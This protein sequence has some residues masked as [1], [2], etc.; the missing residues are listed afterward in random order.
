MHDRG[1]K[2]V[3]FLSNHWD[4]E[5]GKLAL[6][7]RQVL[8]DEVADAVSMYG[9]DGVNID[10]E[11]MTEV[12]R[13]NYTDFVK[14]LSTLLPA[15]KTLA[16]AVAANPYGFEEG[17]Q[18]SYDYK[19]LGQY[20]DYLMIMAYDEHYPG[21]LAGPVAS[22]PFVENSIRYALKTAPS[23]KIVLGI[24]FYGRLWKTGSGTEGYG[25]SITTIEKMINE[26]NGR[27]VYD[28]ESQSSKAVFT[29]RPGEE[30][31]VL[32]GNLLP[33]GTYE[34]WYENDESLKYKL[35]LVQ[36]YN[37]KG[38][39]SWSLGQENKNIWNFYSLWL[40]GHYF[41][42]TS[43]NWALGDIL[44]MVDKGWM[45]GV[46]NTLFMPGKALTRAEAAAEFVRALGLVKQ[47]YDAGFSDIEGHWAKDD[48]ITAKQ[49]GIVTGQGNGLFS[50]E[51]PV[52]REE[53][54][55]MLDRILQQSETPVEE[56]NPYWDVSREENP[57]AYGSILDMTYQGGF[58]GRPDGAF[59]AAESVTRAE[60]AALMNRISSYIGNDFAAIP[61]SNP[62]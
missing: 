44:A 39:G 58:K 46:S 57:W 21:G 6:A 34:V 56:Y 12:D 28:S 2:V 45:K 47:G 14:R 31:F 20:S 32:E 37:L 1:I 26:Y 29:I 38:T 18:A 60:M 9:L 25:I 10:I 23:G 8:A 40:N 50:P 42:D 55:V 41:V 13:N 52:T 7:N 35:R 36:K 27:V 53:M 15:T 30:K 54:A 22:G 33:A 5:L 61:G 43:G 62:S 4:H 51:A 49:N 24:P 3:P 11:N 48:I 16:V 19:A 59:H 17:W